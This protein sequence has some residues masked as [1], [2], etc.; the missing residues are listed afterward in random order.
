M[1]P[2]RPKP[3]ACAIRFRIAKSITRRRLG[4]GFV[5]IAPNGWRLRDEATRQHIRSLVIPPAWTSVWINPLANAHLQAVGRDARGRKQYRYHGEY[6]KV[7][8]QMKFDRM[9]EMLKFRFRGKS[10]Q[11]HEVTVENRRLARILRKC[12]DIPGSALSNTA[13]KKEKRSRSNPGT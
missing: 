7:R 12:K 2:S 10:G 13:T 3:L 4:S 8:D 1:K 5:Y 6:R 9:G 11:R